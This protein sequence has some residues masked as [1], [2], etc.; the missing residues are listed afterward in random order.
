MSLPSSEEWRSI[1]DYEGFYEASDQGRVR[2]VPRTI[3]KATGHRYTYK[4]QLLKAYGDPIDGRRRVHLSR[5]GRVRT[6]T[7]STLVLRA[8]AGPP[9]RD[10]EVCHNDGDATNDRLENLRWDTHSA[11]NYD[12]V[13]H[14]KHP[15]AAK[16]R[17]NRNHPLIAPNLVPSLTKRGFRSCLA[18]HRARANARYAKRTGRPY[19]IAAWADEH[20][21]RIMKG[22]PT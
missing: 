3:T 9:P 5:D 15:L 8:F 6:W 1:P 2:S 12:R 22:V 17:C 7:V 11:N 19:D 18:C 13:Q 14:G 21:D 10:T 4:G 16:A 20:Y